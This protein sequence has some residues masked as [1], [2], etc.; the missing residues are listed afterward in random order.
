[1][2]SQLTS[3]LTE[4]VADGTPASSRD[5]AGALTRMAGYEHLAPSRSVTY[6]AGAELAHLA[7][8]GSVIQLFRRGSACL[9]TPVFKAMNGDRP[10]SVGAIATAL[11]RCECRGWVIGESRAAGCA[12]GSPQKRDEPQPSRRERAVKGAVAQ[13]AAPRLVNPPSPPIQCRGEAA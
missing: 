8:K 6:E 11:V 9:W 4:A 5:A 3:A 12:R 7:L 10:R 1:M 2:E 13:A